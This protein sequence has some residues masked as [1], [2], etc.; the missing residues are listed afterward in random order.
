[1][2]LPARP[3]R[4]EKKRPLD[5][6]ATIGLLIADIADRRLLVDFLQAAGYGVR[7]GALDV[8]EE[9]SL[10]IVD[11]RAGREYGNELVRLKRQ[12]GA[13][14]LPLLVALSANAESTPWL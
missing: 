9:L 11:E 2:A 6:P 3:G 4:T 5:P 14:F 8:W 12:A 13:V 10:I 1:M 7:A